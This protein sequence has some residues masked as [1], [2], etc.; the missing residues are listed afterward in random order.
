[1][2][3]TETVRQ[4]FIYLLKVALWELLCV[5]S[6]QPGILSKAFCWKE[7]SVAI[8]LFI[9]LRVTLGNWLVSLRD[10]SRNQLSDGRTVLQEELVQGEQMS[11]V[12][13]S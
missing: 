9:F 3:D 7:L 10:F 1:M 12:R 5:S 8:K 6:A 11:C 13:N 4:H 2:Q